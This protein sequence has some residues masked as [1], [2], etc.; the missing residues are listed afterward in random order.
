MQPAPQKHQPEVVYRRA[1][2]PGTASGDRRRGF[3]P[4]IVPLVTGFLLLLVLILVLGLR[5]AQKMDDVA[6]N[7][8]ILT[9]SYSTRL[10]RLLELRLA[11]I[12][13]DSEARVRDVSETSRQL[14][15][16][17]EIRLD[18]ARG[19][20]SKALRNVGPPPPPP[21][22]EK[23]ELW[24]QRWNQFLSDVQSY[25]DVTDDVRRYSQ[26]GFHKFRNM[27]S[28]LGVF[29]GAAQVAYD[30]VDKEMVAVHHEAN[31]SILIWITVALFVGALV[32]TGT[33]WQV[34]RH[35]SGM[36][37][38]VLETRRERTL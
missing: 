36:R 33:I 37:R 15:P 31:R 35:F 14:T 18:Q 1:P 22:N 29:V 9:Q 12:K 8:R 26:Q 20:A 34:Q 11:L 17:L 38:S 6:S 28:E 3:A 23:P 4:A 19:E 16:P 10:S 30:N 27:Q 24:E 2:E 5:S 21:V 7:A 32:A 25:I 13:L